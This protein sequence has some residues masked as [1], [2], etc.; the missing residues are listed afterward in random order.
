MTLYFMKCKDIFIYLQRFFFTKIQFKFC[1]RD[2]N[3]PLHKF[4]SKKKISYPFNGSL[5]I[6]TTRNCTHFPKIRFV[7]AGG[8][9]H[10]YHIHQ[11]NKSDKERKIVR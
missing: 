2:L 5:G 7:V 8:G 4:K 1:F 6:A 11:G 3:N 9:F 10:S